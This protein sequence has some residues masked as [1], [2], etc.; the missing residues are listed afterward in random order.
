MDLG[1]GLDH[2]AGGQPRAISGGGEVS[3]PSLARIGS[4]LE[5]EGCKAFPWAHNGEQDDDY[6]LM[7]GV[8]YSHASAGGKKD[9]EFR[10]VFS[11]SREFTFTVDHPEFSVATAKSTIAARS[12]YTASVSFAPTAKDGAVVTARMIVDC[13][14]GDEKQSWTYYL[15]GQRPNES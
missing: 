6:A 12:S 10:N 1:L 15:R 2:R 3:A 5:Q 11:D 7:Y 4:L 9:I 8:A 13:D 14:S